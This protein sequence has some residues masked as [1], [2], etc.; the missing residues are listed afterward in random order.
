[1]V[2]AQPMHMTHITHTWGGVQLRR[3]VWDSY[4]RS[5]TFVAQETSNYRF[6]MPWLILPLASKWWVTH[7]PIVTKKK[8][9]RKKKKEQTRVLFELTQQTTKGYSLC[10]IHPRL[11]PQT[12]LGDL[13][14]LSSSFLPLP[15]LVRLFPQVDLGLF[16]YHFLYIFPSCLHVQFSDDMYTSSHDC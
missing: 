6:I 11:L 15:F 5:P 8:K 14:L 9:K 13:L 16:L 10:G 2:W 3:V 4:V 12:S 7:Y 1:M